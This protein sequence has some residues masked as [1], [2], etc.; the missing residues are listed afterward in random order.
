[1]NK[2]KIIY[3]CLIIPFFIL[4]ALTFLKIKHHEEFQQKAVLAHEIR[5]VLEHLMVDISQAREASFGD[6]ATDGLWHHR[7]S[8]DQVQQ[9]AVE[10]LIKEGHLLRINQG[11][12]LFIADD[13]GDL[14]IRRQKETPDILEIQ[15]EAKKNVSLISNLKIRLRQ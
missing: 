14:R 1:M 3:A 4:I 13:I 7:I 12:T 15:I 9:G 11:K 2:L 5:K 10:Y 8:F 6:V